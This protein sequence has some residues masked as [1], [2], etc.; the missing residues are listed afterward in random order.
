M[1]KKKK[2]IVILVTTMINCLAPAIITQSLKILKLS[3]PSQQVQSTKNIVISS[4]VR[5]LLPLSSLLSQKDI[6]LISLKPKWRLNY[7]RINHILYIT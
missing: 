2:K 6:R 4:L 5:P 7:L 3:S 1:I